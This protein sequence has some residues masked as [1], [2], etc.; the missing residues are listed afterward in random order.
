[1][2]KLAIARILSFLLLLLSI[3]CG[4]PSIDSE[5]IVV[6]AAVSLRDSFVEIGAIYSQRSGRDV[7][8][9]FGSSGVLQKQ[10]E[11]GAPADVFVSAGTVQMDAL[12]QRGLID[13]ESKT[14]IAGNALV[15]IVPTTHS[16]QV[17]DLN[18][19]SGAN[20]ARIAIGN[21]KTVPAGQYTEQ[22]LQQAGL[23]E[24]LRSRLVFG[25][26]VRQVLE[27]VVRG[28]VDAGIVY[29][30]DAKIGGDGVR[31]A[32]VIPHDL[33]DQIIY[34]AAIVKASRHPDAAKAFIELV[35]SDTGR[36][37][38]RSHGFIVD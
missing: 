26:D 20:I 25:E 34:P 8:F 9:N 30:T 31:V 16:N 28:E 19:L 37:I 6:S 13:P 7:T 11:T 12:M 29:A 38:L 22:A 32:F 21:P 3:S 35:H 23:A 5:P 27:Y 17:T 15:A 24:T 10:I 18:E 4:R 2:Y 1:M 36:D 33:H 14:D